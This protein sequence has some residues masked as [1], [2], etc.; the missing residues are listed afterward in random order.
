MKHWKNCDLFPNLLK[1]I[2]FGVNVELHKILN[3]I[4]S[5][6]VPFKCNISLSFTTFESD[7]LGE[8]SMNFI[9]CVYDSLLIFIFSIFRQ[10]RSTSIR[11][12]LLSRDSTRMQP[13][14]SWRSERSRRCSNQRCVSCPQRLGHS[15]ERPHRCCSSRM[16]WRRVNSQPDASRNVEKQFESCACCGG[17]ESN[18]YVVFWQT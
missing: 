4:L 16:C 5:A 18:M 10:I 9:C 6:V 11:R 13:S 2:K 8:E 15:L 14:V 17:A 3:Y 12:R 1:L 7:F